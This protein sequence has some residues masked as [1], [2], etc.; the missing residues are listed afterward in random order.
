MVY[1]VKPSVLKDGTNN[2][3]KVFTNID[4]LIEFISPC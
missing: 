4:D 3:F 2:G 1:S